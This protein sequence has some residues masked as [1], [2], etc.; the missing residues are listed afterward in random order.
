MGRLAHLAPLV[1]WPSASVGLDGGHNSLAELFVGDEGMRGDR[2]GTGETGNHET[3]EE[4]GLVMG[5]MCEIVG[6]NQVSPRCHLWAVA[7]P[8]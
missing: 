3:R 7:R 5:E 2:K 1:R 8:S 6:R 4:R